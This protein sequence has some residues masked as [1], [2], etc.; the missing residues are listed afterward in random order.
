[1]CAGASLLVHYSPEQVIWVQALA[2]DVDSVLGKTHLVTLSVPPSTQLY[3]CIPENLKG[4]SEPHLCVCLL[5]RV[6]I[7]HFIVACHV[8][9]YEPMNNPLGVS[10]S[11][12]NMGTT[13]GKEKIF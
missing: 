3:K 7:L 10:P 5:V 4:P 1:M 6:W 9:E 13:R 11:K 2:K 8:T 12:G